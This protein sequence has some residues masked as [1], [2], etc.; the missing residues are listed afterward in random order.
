MLNSTTFDLC[1]PSFPLIKASSERGPD[2]LKHLLYLLPHIPGSPLSTIL[3]HHVLASR[4]SAHCAVGGKTLTSMSSSYYYS[5]T[6]QVYYESESGPSVP[7]LEGQSWQPTATADDQ[8]GY[9]QPH[10]S[11]DRVGILLNVH[12][13]EVFSCHNSDNTSIHSSSLSGLQDM[14][15]SPNHPCSTY[16]LPSTPLHDPGIMT[17]ATYTN[18]GPLLSSVLHSLMI[19]PDV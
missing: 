4:V 12:D 16:S 13:A 17:N 18:V 5:D 19:P 9:S 15:Y 3:F 8:T 6:S 2:Y 11:V 14:N 1:I 10:Q 7:Q